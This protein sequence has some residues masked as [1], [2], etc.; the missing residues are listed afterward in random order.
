VTNSDLVRWSALSEPGD[1]LAGLVFRHFGAEAALEQFQNKSARRLWAELLREEHPGYLARLDETIERFHLRWPATEPKALLQAAVRVGARPIDQASAPALWG[2]FL[3][4]E[5]H[6]PS[7]LWAAGD[8]DFDT[9][10]I[11][12]VGTRL[13]TDYGLE[14]TEDLVG[15]LVGFTIVSGGAKGI[16]AAAHRAALAAANQT[17]AYLAG[18]IDVAYPRENEALFHQ[19]VASGGAL[20]AETAPTTRPSRWRFLQRNRLIA[21]HGEVTVIV[22][23]G[24]KSGAKNTA[25]RAIECH[26]TVFAVPGQIT[27]SAS[28][29]C[30]ELIAHGK[31]T[32]LVDIGDFVA[33]LT[34]QAQELKFESSPTS[35]QVRVLDAMTS[36]ARTVEQIAI[37]SGLGLIQCRVELGRLA[38]LG[39]VK[40]R[41]NGWV[42]IKK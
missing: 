34:G 8:P 1:G 7:M 3:E 11:S 4:L 23:A 16:D 36:Q 40:E 18:G 10:P 19:I 39:V 12:V 37:E 29:T 28:A 42:K 27:S 21:A 15:R 35:E 30:N 25:T 38:D 26:R 9:I 13:P 6:A 31:A 22:E 24:H 14:V 17:I 32:A 2:Q 33:D 41:L 20:L 5:H